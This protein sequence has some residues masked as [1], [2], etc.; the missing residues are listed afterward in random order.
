MGISKQEPRARHLA[1]TSPRNASQESLRLWRSQIPTTYGYHGKVC[2][3]PRQLARHTIWATWGYERTWTTSDCQATRLG[4]ASNRKLQ[5]S[6]HD[7]EPNSPHWHKHEHQTFL[8]TAGSLKIE[9]RWCRSAHEHHLRRKRHNLDAVRAQ[10]SLQHAL[11]KEAWHYQIWPK[12]YF[13][14]RHDGCNYV[15]IT[16]YQTCSKH[17]KWLR[18]HSATAS[19][20]STK[21]SKECNH[22]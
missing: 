3:T 12:R 20:R 7:K 18:K 4:N 14:W 2:G 17:W 10:I 11:L 13:W 6:I 21:H 9:Q 22:K 1:E 5:N 16:N 8:E 19:E 15:V